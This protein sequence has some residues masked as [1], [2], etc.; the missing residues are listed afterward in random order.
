MS[1]DLSSRG[2]QDG[3]RIDISQEQ[4]C[5]YWSRKLGVRPKELKRAVRAVG[6]RVEDVE[7]RLADIRMEM[8]IGVPDMGT[9]D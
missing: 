2:V 7:Q 4:E 1:E 5:R 8:P 6:D 9:V 3:T